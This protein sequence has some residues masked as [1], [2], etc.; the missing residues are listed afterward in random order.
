MALTLPILPKRI[1][2]FCGNVNFPT[3]IDFFSPKASST[4]VKTGEILS[5]DESSH[6]HLQNRVSGLKVIG[7]IYALFIPNPI[8]VDPFCEKPLS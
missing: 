6:A 4:S 5:T 7:L 2:L 8:S 1:S 3:S